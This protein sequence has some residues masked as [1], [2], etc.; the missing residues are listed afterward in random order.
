M[1]TAEA[2]ESMRFGSKLKADKP[3]LGNDTSVFF[4]NNVGVIFEEYKEGR[5]KF[6]K[7]FSMRRFVELTKDINFET[8]C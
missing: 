2:M 7:M 8:I 4:M 1:K 6:E 3:I 5:K